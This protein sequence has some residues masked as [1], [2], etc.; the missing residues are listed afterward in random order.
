M[1]QNNQNVK[2]GKL[3]DFFRRLFSKIDK[4]LEEKS[5]EGKCCCNQDSKIN[6]AAVNC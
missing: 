1:E 4:G 5:K 6:H 2:G 3:M